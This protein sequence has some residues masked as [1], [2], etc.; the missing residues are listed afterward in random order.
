M[1]SENI[2]HG[3]SVSIVE[4][5]SVRISWENYFVDIPLDEEGMNKILN[6]IKSAKAKSFIQSLPPEI[7]NAVEIIV[8]NNVDAQINEITNKMLQSDGFTANGVR[9]VRQ[10][11]E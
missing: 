2:I 5:N 7:R 1:D 4:N 3:C 9:F 11:E 10:T 8:Q 6:I